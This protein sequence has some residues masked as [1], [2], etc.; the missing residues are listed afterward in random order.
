MKHWLIGTVAAVALLTGCGNKD[1]AADANGSAA[2]EIGDVRLPA[3]ELRAGDAAKAEDAL[4]ALSLAESGSGR[5]SFSNRDVSGANATFSDVK[6]LTGDTEDG[7]TGGILAAQT[8]TFAGLDMADGSAAFAQMKL[9]GV[10]LSSVGEDEEVAVQIADLQ[11]SNPSPALAAWV[12]SLFGQGDPAAF[13]EPA[14][15]SFDAFS[16]NKIS[17]APEADDEIGELKIDRIDFREM[18]ETGLGAMVFEGLNLSTEEDGGEAVNMSLGSLQILGVG[19][20]IAK[21]FAAGLSDADADPSDLLSMLASNPG[22][23]GYDSVRL[24]DLKLDAAGLGIDLPSYIADVTRDNQGRAV[25]S[26]TE[27][28]KATISVDPEGEIGSEMAGQLGLLGY[29]TLVIGGAGD[30]RIDH[31]NDLVTADAGSNYFELEDGFRLSMGGEF[32]GLSAFYNKLAESELDELDQSPLEFATM[33]SEL[34]LNGLELSLED[35]SFMDRAFAAAAAQQGGTP[36]EMKTQVKQMLGL[37]PVFAG[38]SGVDVDI[39]TEFT[40]AL[41]SFI[42][43]PGTLTLKLDPET[44]LTADMLENPALLTK[45]VLGFSA[46]S[47]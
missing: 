40:N 41:G 10:T 29:E 4:T 43:D 20:V 17:L 3:I 18:S 12:G 42:S 19:E 14:E 33:L 27:P 22:D 34:N 32:G 46:S 38:S 28:F 23:P 5:V 30:S 37:A 35:N 11:I 15:L 16:V 45:D 1:K 24:T 6:I 36:E 7:D 39:V 21:S 8:L 44:P 9:D 31:E 2:V 25:R 47:K 13:P 26:Q